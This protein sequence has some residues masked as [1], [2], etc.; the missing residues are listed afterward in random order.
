MSS[1]RKLVK[2]QI[3]GGNLA[4]SC[5]YEISPGDSWRLART[6]IAHLLRR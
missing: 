2:K 6:G 3:D 5:D 4:V 1:S